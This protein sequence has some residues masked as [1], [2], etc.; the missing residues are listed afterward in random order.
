MLTDEQI[1][2]LEAQ[3][4]TI[5]VVRN[6]RSDEMVVL[7]KPTRAEYKMFRS[8]ANNPQKHESA[9]ETL[10]RQIAVYPDAAGLERLFDGEWLALDQACGK[11][12]VALL[13]T[14]GDESLK[15]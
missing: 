5:A 13:G 12:L 2:T 3:Y 11:A 7:R 6:P 4:K 9:Q 1:A 14:T 15:G 10:V 8:N